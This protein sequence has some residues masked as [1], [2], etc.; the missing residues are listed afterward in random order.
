[1][2]NNII[3]RGAEAVIERHGLTVIKKRVAKGYRYPELDEKLRK[4][5]TRSEA[6]L[7]EKAQSLISVPRLITLNEIKKTLELEY[8]KGEKLADNLEKI[9]EKVRIYAQIGASIAKL[10]DAGIIHGDLTTS[11]MIYNLKDKKMYLIDFGLGYHSSRIEDKAVDLHVLEEALTAR[12]PT[13]AEK[14]W[15]TIIKNYQHSTNALLVIKQLKKVE[16]RG[17][18]KTQ[19]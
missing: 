18:Y 16:K 5:R 15:K 19:Y 9:K 12:H 14:A 13:I 3:A 10:H 8:I 1:M 2:R 4:L 6:K 17:R 7:L 11:N